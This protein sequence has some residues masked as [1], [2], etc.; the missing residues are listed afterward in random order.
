MIISSK[1]NNQKWIWVKVPKTGTRAYSKLFYPH[2]EP[3]LHFHFTFHELYL[4]HQKQYMGFTVVRNPLTRFISAL[5]HL[6]ELDTFGKLP[7]DTIE[8]LTNFLYDNFHQNCIPKN[9]TPLTTIFGID[10]IN[11]HESFFK[12]QVHWA[13][14][15][16]VHWF[17]YEDLSVFNRWLN[18]NLGM[19]T[20]KLERIGVTKDNKLSHL[21][22]TDANFI[23]LAEYLFHDDYK[24][25]NYS[26]ST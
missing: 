9:D 22:F 20:S 24:V 21:D 13:Y 16:K 4:Q 17:K 8:N 18:V 10:Y 25:F 12:T 6:A 1:I 11:Y 3:K 14:H 2:D 19:D 5:K 7:S 26:V 15:P 23:K